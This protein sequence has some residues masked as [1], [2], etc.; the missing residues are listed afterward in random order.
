MAQPVRTGAGA[1]AATA[2]PE[3]LLP[4]DDSLFFKLVRLVNLTARPFQEGVGKSLHLTLNEWRVMLVLASHPDVAATDVASYTGL[5]KMSVSRALAALA[6]AGR[7]KR[8]TDRT[9][10][11]RALVTLSAAGR[12][13]FEQVGVRAKQREAHFMR[14]ISAADLAHMT[15][16]VNAMTDN[17]L[18]EPADTP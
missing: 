14:N 16:V 1:R 3:P 10:N 4:I 11:R 15:R 2:A 13:V 18:D 17:V 8:R 6:R 9:D 7:I 12:R 5:D